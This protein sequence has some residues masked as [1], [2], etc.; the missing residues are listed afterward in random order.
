MVLSQWFSKKERQWFILHHRACTISVDLGAHHCHCLRYTVKRQR[1]ANAHVGQVRLGNHALG[2][3]L[4]D[5]ERLVVQS[6]PLKRGPCREAIT[7]RHGGLASIGFQFLTR[8]VADLAA[9]RRGNPLPE[10]HGLR[11][12]FLAGPETNLAAVFNRLAHLSF[13][14]KAQN[15]ALRDW[16]STSECEQRTGP[17]G[18]GVPF[19]RGRAV[20][21]LVPHPEAHGKLSLFPACYWGS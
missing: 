4:R 16:G 15:R 5:T 20:P 18:L 11:F 2:I 13:S 14:Y 21:R 9:W 17:L 3:H 12:Y 7:H 6:D 1:L 10:L 19:A 8:T